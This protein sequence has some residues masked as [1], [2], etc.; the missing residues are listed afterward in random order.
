[1]A[2]FAP[3]AIATREASDVDPM[4]QSFVSRHL[5]PTFNPGVGGLRQDELRAIIL[6]A[7]IFGVVAYLAM[8][9]TLNRGVT[10]ISPSNGIVLAALL[11]VRRTSSRTAIIA[12]SMAAD[13]FAAAVVHRTLFASF[14]LPLIDAVEILTAFLILKSRERLPLQFRG[15]RSLMSFSMAAIAACAAAATVAGIVSSPSH[16]FFDAH[17]LF[18][19]FVGHLLGLLTVTPALI[20]FLRRPKKVRQTPSFYERYG[21]LG[22][23]VVLTAAVI[24]SYQAPFG[25][26]LLPIL[27][28]IAYRLGPRD[29]SAAV[30][31][32]S[33]TVLLCTVLGFD[34]GA[35]IAPTSLLGGTQ[36]LQLRM[37][38]TF[39]TVMLLAEMI[40]SQVRLRARLSAELAYRSD[41][42][43]HLKSQ[44]EALTLQTVE[45][46]KTHNRLK[47]AI[48]ILPE[49]M[50][51]LDADDR[52]VAWNKRY[53]EI[54]SRTADMLSVGGT[55]KSVVQAGLER[56]LYPEAAGRE[57]E[58]LTENL[59]KLRTPAEPQEQLL[60][61]RCYLVEE[62]RTSEGGLISLQIDITDI[63]KRESS[64]VYMARH[65]ALTSLPNR[66]VLTER[67]HAATTCAHRGERMALLLLDLDNF[68]T[69]NDTLGHAAGDELL[70]AVADRLR[71][72]LREN[73]TVHKLGGDEFAVLV[74]VSQAES[75]VTTAA[76]ILNILNEPIRIG[77]KDVVCSASV[78]IAITP[79]HTCEAIELFRLA[80]LALYAAKAMGRGTYCMFDPEL[81]VRF[82]AKTQLQ[83]EVREAIIG[84]QFEIHYQL[85]T[86]LS[87]LKPVGAEALVR[88]RRP[89][90]GS[91]SA[92]DFISI[93]EEIGMI[94][95]LGDKILRQACL[96]AATWPDDMSVS[97]N[98]SATELEA[99]NFIDT[100]KC[101]LADS[102]LAC[103]RLIIEVTESTVMKDVERS[104]RVL[105]NIRDLGVE[106]AMDDFGTGYSS[107][108]SLAKV[109]FQKI[110]I[111]R[112]FV[113]DLAS[114]PEA[115]AILATIVDLA[116]TLGMTTTAEGIE[117]AE[118]LSIVKD[119]GCTLMQ[120]YLFHRPQPAE[121]VHTL[122]WHAC[123][124]EQNAA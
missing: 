62:K 66:H 53:A 80:D 24:T 12:F 49:G 108:G 97:V 6:T 4:S 120:G 70:K 10:T 117:T 121:Q 112:S 98:V 89:R 7:T 76:R 114:S 65:D 1:M 3:V 26:V 107:L 11:F 111:D 32:V 94:R 5:L 90:Q 31:L 22:L 23:L 109:P 19:L 43:R 91:V 83:A 41:L 48:D 20:R 118:Q 88:W 28:T 116:R 84:D 57:D 113:R 69:V 123:D 42:N 56:G 14:G 67:M 18:S 72:S 15:V 104:A 13:A 54:Y 77:S 102:G 101:A 45:L 33:G 124:P 106:V 81:D 103:D 93:A 68:K 73:D 74:N 47:E 30:L 58:W 87:T 27:I 96:E 95:E 44:E 92:A 55:V 39:L 46:E 86:S 110:K 75:A 119:C 9:F 36:L 99:D 115:R 61:G 63:K 59:K 29:T 21:L 71:N 16:K 34:P 37:L 2:S 85:I 60:D 51:I 100:V 79:D 122:M 40:A 105:R 8:S 35:K 64:A 38:T 78:G 52:Y 17:A 82:K 25:F 50:V